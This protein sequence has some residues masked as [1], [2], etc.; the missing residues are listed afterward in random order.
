MVAESRIGVLVRTGAH[1]HLMD[2]AS[3]E[4]DRIGFERHRTAA[5]DI[6]PR[7]PPV[8]AADFG[9]RTALGF[10]RF[11]Q[12]S[13]AD[14]LWRETLALAD[15]HGLADMST[16][17]RQVLGGLDGCRDGAVS[18]T[19]AFDVPPEVTALAA[20]LRVLAVHAGA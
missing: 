15:A 5:R 7:M 2:L 20:D 4:G 13:R 8:V 14:E 19:E 1:V 10:A 16:M 12:F 11:G 9:F 17:I 3:G 6:V 18:R